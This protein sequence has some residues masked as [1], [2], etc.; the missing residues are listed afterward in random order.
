MVDASGLAGLVIFRRFEDSEMSLSLSLGPEKACS[1]LR[2]RNT[3]KIV[4]LQEHFV[5]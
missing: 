3:K 4:T 5:S 1:K 2:S